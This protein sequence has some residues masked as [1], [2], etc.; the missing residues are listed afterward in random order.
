M[1]TRDQ[2]VTNIRPSIPT[3]IEASAISPEER[4][5]NQ[6]LR[7]ILKMQNDLL[8]QIFKHYTIKRKGVFNKLSLTK[9]L[10]Y[11]EHNVRKDLRFRNILIG[12]VI[13]YFTLEEWK[14]YSEYESELRKRLVNM[15]VER[16]KSQVEQI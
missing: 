12:S 9:R 2:K 10:D 5:Q 11:I 14:S 1:N 16:L 8:V 7:P 4:F 6:T 3:I 15:L 13:G